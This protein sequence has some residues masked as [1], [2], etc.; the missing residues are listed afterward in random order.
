MGA[1]SEQGGI[2]R[3]HVVSIHAL[4]MGAT[5]FWYIG[6]LMTCFNPRARD[7][8]DIQDDRGDATLHEFQST[9][10]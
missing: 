7:G 8:R 3:C 10:S 4:V 2:L 9:R 1:T 5:S 6:T